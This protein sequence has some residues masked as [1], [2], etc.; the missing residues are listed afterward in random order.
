MAPGRVAA[1]VELLDAGTTH[2]GRA[3]AASDGDDGLRAAA[4][5]ATSALQDLGHSVEMEDLETVMTFGAPL[6]VV[7]VT[8]EHEGERDRLMGFCA[9]RDGGLRAAVLAVLNA[10]MDAAQRGEIDAICFAPLNKFAMKQGGLVRTRLM[11]EM[12]AAAGLRVVVGHGFGLTLSTLAEAALAASS[13][14]VIEG[15]E[16]VGPLKMAGDVVTEPVR[17]DHGVLRL[18][19]APGLGAAIDP[20]ACKRYRADR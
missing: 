3:E 20:D 15:C 17:L 4:L 19:D 2:V 16:A 8:A 11:I 1:R 18:P 10:C 14:A 7:R 9:V 5:A 13:A 12:A 6:V